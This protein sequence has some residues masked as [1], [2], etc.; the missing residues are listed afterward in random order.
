MRRM[1]VNQPST[2][3]KFHKYNGANVLE[4]EHDKDHKGTIFTRIYFTSGPV[5][6]TSVTRAS[7]SEGWQTQMVRL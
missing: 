2:L 5:H 6:S 7:L 3:Q 4:D 1:W